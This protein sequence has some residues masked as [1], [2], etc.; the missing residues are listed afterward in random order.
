[1]RQHYRLFVLLLIGFLPFISQAAGEPVGS[2]TINGETIRKSLTGE[3]ITWEEDQRHVSLVFEHQKT[4]E[5]VFKIALMMCGL[6]KSLL[7]EAQFDCGDK[8]QRCAGKY[9]NFRY[10]YAPKML[11]GAPSLSKSTASATVSA[12]RYPVK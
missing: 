5:T 8:L 11:L 10:A 4:D 1:M 7:G 6:P 9:A 3:S 12:W 2:V